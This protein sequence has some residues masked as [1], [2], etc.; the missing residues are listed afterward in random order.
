MSEQINVNV[1][2]IEKNETENSVEEGT[3]TIEEMAA[4]INGLTDE[5]FDNM[6]EEEKA[7]LKEKYDK[8][9]DDAKAKAAAELAKEETLTAL[10]R[11]RRDIKEKLKTAAVDL[12]FED[13][14]YGKE[15]LIT[16]HSLNVSSPS[17]ESMILSSFYPVDK[18]AFIQLKSTDKL[19][20][21]AIEEAFGL[22]PSDIIEDVTLT[23][24]TVHTN[25]GKL[26]LGRFNVEYDEE[27]LNNMIKNVA[28]ELA[29]ECVLEITSGEKITEKEP[30]KKQSRFNTKM[31]VKSEYVYEDDYELDLD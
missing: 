2:E 3:Q 22:I 1:D 30:E 5:D 9:N 23:Y 20:D 17:I 18:V 24:D 27:G 26:V 12:Y 31:E 19:G 6:T 16:S 8:V 13:T 10:Q 15:D 14:I 21:N 29:E 28:T 7:E 4:E 11:N 25:Y